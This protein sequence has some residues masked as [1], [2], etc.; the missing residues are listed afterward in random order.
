MIDHDHIN[1]LLPIYAL[2]CLDNDEAALVSQHLAV[3]DTCQNRLTEYRQS[4]D[5]LVHVAPE[6]FP[7][8]TL[9]T[10]LLR[11]IAATSDTHGRLQRTP[12]KR[13]MGSR[14]FPAW[15]IVGLI[16]IVGLAGINL[17]QWQNHLRK[18]QAE[19][20]G[21]LLIVRMKGTSRAPEGDG[22]FVIG[23]DCKQAV[24]VAS[25][26]PVLDEGHQ[27]QL[28]MV[29]DEQRISGGIFSVGSN[30]YATVK[31]YSK[32]LLTNFRTFE[33]TVEPTGGSLKP[34][35]YLVMVSLN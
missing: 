17:M 7:P 33:V 6:V 4:V 3:C 14:F 8:N 27:Y 29:K 9:K 21:E 28:W 10:Q 26:L 32:E 34:G 13:R 24:L 19:V 2:G 25:D 11:R 1:D 18:I 23:Q 35:D 12:P 31:I 22:T 16:I 30:G 20:A 15:A 5:L